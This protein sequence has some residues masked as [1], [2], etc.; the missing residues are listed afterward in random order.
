M[1]TTV[2]DKSPL[3]FVK[4][5]KNGRNKSEKTM[6]TGTLPL[7]PRVLVKTRYFTSAVL[8]NATFSFC[9]ARF[10][11]TYVFAVDPAIVGASMMPYVAGYS[12]LYS[13]YRT[14]RSSISVSFTNNE[15]TSPT[16]CYI[17]FSPVDPGVNTVNWWN[18]LAHVGTKHGVAGPYTSGSPNVVTLSH[19]LTTEG[20]AGSKWG[21]LPDDFSSD[22]AGISGP[23]T[24][25][26]YFVV[27]CYN[28]TN[29]TAGKGV[30]IHVTMDVEFDVF[31]EH[32][33]AN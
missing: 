15:L 5:K 24:L 4:R 21:G 23:P 1:Q 25:A 33:P 8:N 17:G 6:I 9:N 14:R 26:W 27:G 3:T 31:D 10:D 11:P 7:P 19:S 20:I 18:Y 13:L 32:M 29:F 12:N 16:Y 30:T 22:L 28:L 2:E